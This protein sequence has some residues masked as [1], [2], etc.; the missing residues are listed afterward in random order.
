MKTTRRFPFAALVLALAVSAADAARFKIDSIH[1]SV[2]FKVRHMVVSKTS[3]QFNDF[4]GWFEYDPKDKKGRTWKAY[5]E[6]DVASVDTANAKRDAHLRTP[7]FFDAENHPKMTFESTEVVRRKGDLFLVGELTLRGVTKTVELE[8]EEN[9]VIAGRGGA[10][11]AGFTARG[12]LDR[13]AY[14]VSF[15]RVLETG[16]LAVG[17]EVEITLEIEGIEEKPKKK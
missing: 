6:I 15:S 5:A 9:G 4:S 11:H 7:D 3:G 13:Q 8:L 12:K 2:G 14:G 1:S 17:N 16:G 10:L